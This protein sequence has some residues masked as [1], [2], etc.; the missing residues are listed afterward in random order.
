MVLDRT[1]PAYT[2]WHIGF[3]L[4]VFSFVNKGLFRFMHWISQCEKPQQCSWQNGQTQVDALNLFAGVIFPPMKIDCIG[5]LDQPSLVL[6]QFP[7]LRRG[8]SVAGN[9]KIN[10]GLGIILLF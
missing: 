6:A 9:F 4:P 5:D 10:V 8:F 2:S 1:F 7:Y 3:V